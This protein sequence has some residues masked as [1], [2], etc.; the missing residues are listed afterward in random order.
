M[1]K[2]LSVLL[3][4]A[5]V[6]SLGGISQAVSLQTGPNIIKTW[7][8][9]LG[10]SYSGGQTGHFYFRDAAASYITEEHGL[11]TYD[12]LN[13]NHHL[14]T[15]LGAGYNPLSQNEDAWGLLRITQIFKGDILDDSR[16]GDGSDAS[17]I[18]ND[19]SANT[20]YWS[21]G[22]G[23]AANEYLLG[24]F[25]GHKDLVVECVNAAQSS[26]RIWGS[27]GEFDIYV[28]NGF[29]GNPAVAAN[30]TPANRTG[31]DSFDNWFDKVNDE[32]FVGGVFEY[33][34][35]DG[36][37]TTLNN[38][39]GESEVLMNFTRGTQTLGTWGVDESNWWRA[40]DGTMA[41]MWQSWNIGDPFVYRNGW[42]GSE[43]SGRFYVPVPE[44][45]TI[46]GMIL[47]MGGLTRYI[48]KR[49]SL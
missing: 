41:D 46:V 16:F 18:G 19:I 27:G 43:D 9:E 21:E 25:Y 33:F 29:P 4:S 36:N 44:P 47:G 38:F 22:A 37:A 32:L 42:T 15:D 39:D 49:R 17:L 35:F 30:L 7:N 48:R 8:Y 3:V 28:V 14:F 31:L 20:S 40:P 26:Y 23:N 1:K 34:R 13:P 10:S 2:L 24:M 11:L 5:L 12:P 6:L 45:V